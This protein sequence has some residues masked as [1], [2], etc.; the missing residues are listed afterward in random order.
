M[1]RNLHYGKNFSGQLWIM[2]ENKSNGYFFLSHSSK[3]V[4]KVR[5]I[6]NLI[7]SENGNPIMF[8]LKCLDGDDPSGEDKEQLKGLISREIMARKKF[9]LCRSKY[10]ESP[11]SSEWIEWEKGE[12]KRLRKSNKEIQVHEIDIEDDVNYLLNVRDIVR[13]Q[14]KILLVVPYELRDKRILVER[15][16]IQHELDV[17]SIV[18]EGDIHTDLQYK[19]GMATKD[20]IKGLIQDAASQS[21]IMV[22]LNS[23]E[24][25]S[26]TILQMAYTLGM[27]CNCSI[28]SYDIFDLDENLL[29]QISTDILELIYS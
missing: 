11:L 26:S 19:F 5:L 1:S 24:I 7:E 10:T 18:E 3:D 20:M 2:V 8:Y 17:V 21:G 15:V 12:V 9:I 4:E 29:T 25:E 13:K 16:L 28:K 6:R 27:G 23:R 14:R 22:L